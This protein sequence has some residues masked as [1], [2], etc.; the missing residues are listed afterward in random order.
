ME[1]DLGCFD[2]LDPKCTCTLACLAEGGNSCAV[3]CGAGQLPAAHAEMIYS[4]GVE[5]CANF[6][7]G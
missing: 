3:Q 6:C 2:G 1:V 4:C 7:G 5:L